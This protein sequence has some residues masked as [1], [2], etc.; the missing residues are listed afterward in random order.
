MLAA[1][2]VANGGSILT[3]FTN[4]KEMEDCYAAVNPV[5]K[6][7]DLR[8][9]CQKWGVSVKSLRDEFIEDNSVSLFALKSFWEGF[10]APGST[11]R[12]VV[13]PKLPFQKPSDPLSCERAARDDYAWRNYVLPQA[14][15]EVRQAVGRLIRKAEDRGI[16]V[17][18]DVRLVSK[19]YGRVFVKSLPTKNVKIMPVS[20]IVKDIEAN[21]FL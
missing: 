21:L 6:D 10:D 4:K 12:G 15:L 14:V 19:G 18:G 13:I 7:A 9:I 11:L 20:E 17:F 5:V 16:V 1:V 2:H 3:L 8:L